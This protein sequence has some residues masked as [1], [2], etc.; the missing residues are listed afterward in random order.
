[1]IMIALLDACVLYSAILRDLLLRLSNENVFIPKWSE[2]INQEWTRNLLASRPDLTP[3]RLQRTC[4]LMLASNPDSLVTGFEKHIAELTLP[5]PNDRHVVAAAI[6]SHADVIVTFNLKDFPDALLAPHQIKAIH[7]DVFLC[8]CL[9]DYPLQ[10][11][12]AIHKQQQSLKSPP[13]SMTKFLEVLSQAGL[14]QTSTNLKEE[15]HL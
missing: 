3:D 9:L 5:D 12:T 13:C 14:P 15:L 4:H 7:P 10:V 2:T 1:M 11:L 6:E 8:Q